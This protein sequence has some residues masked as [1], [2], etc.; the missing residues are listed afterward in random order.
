[1]SFVVY[2]LIDIVDFNEW[3]SNT[4]THEKKI[5]KPKAPKIPHKDGVRSG[6]R[7]GSAKKQNGPRN[8]FVGG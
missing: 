7:T 2:S 8:N 1:M 6:A 4:F 5:K 3:L